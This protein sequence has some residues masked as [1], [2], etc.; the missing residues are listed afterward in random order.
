MKPRALRRVASWVLLAFLCLA[1]RAGAQ[2]AAAPLSLLD[3]PFI[4]QSEL[5][6]GGAAAAMVLRYWGE[7]GVAADAF[8]PLVDRRAGGIPTNALIENIRG[9]GWKVAALAGTADALGREIDRG[10]PPMLLIEDR[11]NA[12]HYVVVVGVT[13]QAVVFHD[14]ARMPFRV[15]SRDEFDRRWAASG[16]WMAQVMPDASRERPSPVA[17]RAPSAETSCERLVS[18]GV[19]QAQANDLDAAAMTLTVALT[20]S[21]PAPLRELA[22]VRLL[23][24]RWGEVSDLASAALSQDPKDDQAWRLLATSRFIEDDRL[25][26]LEAWNQVG[27]PR[28]DLVA[29]NGLEKTR[30]PVV[31]RFLG[32]PENGLLTP[33]LFTVTRRRLRDV[34]SLSTTHLDFVPVKSGLAELHATVSE[35]PL[36]PHGLVDLGAFAINAIFRREVDASFGPLTGGADR[37]TVVWRFWPNR[38]RLGA[39]F[40]APAPWGGLWAVDAFTERQPFVDDVLPIAHRRGA[41]LGVSIWSEHWLRLSARAGTERWRSVGDF[42]L[43]GG[44]VRAV[45]PDDRIDLRLDLTRWLGTGGAVSF[46]NAEFGAT[47]RSSMEHRGRVLI[48][49]AGAAAATVATPPDIWFAGDTGRARGVP[50]R[51]HPAI[52]G[53]RLNTEQ[54][55]R[56][57]QYASGEFQQWWSYRTKALIGAAAFVDTARADRRLLPGSKSDVDAG[58]GLR[59]SAPG[60]SGLVRI[61]IAHGLRDGDDA[62]SFVYEP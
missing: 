48:G 13:K 14:P 39:S 56:R 7:R 16:R 5:L 23:Q 20:C 37:F 40:T 17:S 9:R 6:C 25:G 57:L 22:G 30:Q 51:A 28:V 3:V 34:P 12:F 54:T 61:D 46:G 47:V 41:H 32:V 38:P 33:G 19:Q 11:A 24:K 8:A 18:R 59:V 15:M 21:G 58:V 60:F 49:R 42:G 10:R 44:G 36:V 1:G 2:P 43:I 53:G 62:L 26:A 4:S 52:E 50:L 55:G 45:T 35:R 27:E 29:I 31:H